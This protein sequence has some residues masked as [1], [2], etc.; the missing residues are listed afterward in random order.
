MTL[1]NGKTIAKKINEKTAERVAELKEKG[2]DIKLAVV[3]VGDD[4]P[5]EKYVKRK[6]KKAEKVGIDFALHRFPADIKKE[7]LVKNIKEIQKENLSGMI[8]QLP[9]PEPLYTDEVLNAIDP[10]ID[11]DCLTNENL[12]KLVMKTS[13]IAPPTPGAVMSVLKDLKINLVGKDVTIIG[14]GALVGKPLAIMMANKKASITTCN[15]STKNIKEKCLKADIIVTGVGK[16]DILTAD[17]VSK[18]TIVIDTG[19]CFEDNK[20]YGDVDVEEV[21]KKASFVTPTP[22]GIGPIT[23][24]RLLKNT[25]ICAEHKQK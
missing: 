22:G 4:A 25:V 9:L 8:V 12:G 17:M 2:I 23:V 21:N 20:M 16:K 24:A 1:I 15:S 10:S 11:V 6:G 14:M 7:E 13:K 3:L 5:S 19:I 18:N